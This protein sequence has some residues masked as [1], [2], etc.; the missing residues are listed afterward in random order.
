M[1]DEQAQAQAQAQALVRHLIAESTEGRVDG[2]TIEDA[3][4]L[5]EFGIDSLATVSLLVSLAEKTHV[6]LEDFLDDLETPRS[7]GE[8]VSLAKTFMLS[9]PIDA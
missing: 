5:H 2:A 1:C 8:L 7:V 3:Q 6:D 9:K 4:G